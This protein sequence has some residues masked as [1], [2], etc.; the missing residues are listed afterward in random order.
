MLTLSK[1]Y[2]NQLSVNSG[3]GRSQL[4]CTRCGADVP[5][6][7]VKEWDFQHNYFHVKMYPCP[8]CKK[9]IF[10]YYHEGKLRFTI[11]KNVT[12]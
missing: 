2:I 12:E 8:N 9:N 3:L 5:H 4:K 10:E 11:P 7:S 1:N 6:K